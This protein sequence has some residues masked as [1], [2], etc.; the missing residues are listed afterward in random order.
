M[1]RRI[2]VIAILLT[3]PILL[4]LSYLTEIALTP[5]HAILNRLVADYLS[6]RKY[7]PN[8]PSL[9]EIIPVRPRVSQEIG[10]NHRWVFYTNR[11]NFPTWLCDAELV[12]RGWVW[13][14]L[15]AGCWSGSHLP[16]DPL[17][18]LSWWRPENTPSDQ[19]G[20][21]GLNND[22]RI[23]RLVVNLTNGEPVEGLV[24]AGGF[25]V[26]FPAGVVAPEAL[27]GEASAGLASHLAPATIDAF[28]ATGKLLHHF[29]MEQLSPLRQEPLS[30]TTTGLPYEFI[31]PD[32]LVLYHNLAGQ[33]YV[34]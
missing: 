10:V 13:Q 9:T 19:S 29:T 32:Y 22:E 18:I 15:T 7:S 4:W 1:E 6:L 23:T 28:D 30:A 2:L 20:M 34:R 8:P 17:V 26:V 3:V 12:R 5:S 31:S 16:R 14:T 27:G 24:Q 11:K 21:A 25:L 33:A